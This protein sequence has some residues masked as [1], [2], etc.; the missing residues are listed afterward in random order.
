MLPKKNRVDKK[1]IEK[2]FQEGKF[3]N[4][5][6]L[7]FKFILKKGDSTP[8]VSFL[9]PKSA[10]KKAVTRNLLRRKSYFVLEKYFDKLPVNLAGVF[11][12]NK[13]KTSP[14]NLEEE[15]KIILDKLTNKIK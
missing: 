14:Y 11:V 9:V 6:N 8:Q 10:V 4:S 2:I 3:I 15:I 1:I 13:K 12:F 7:T 5:P